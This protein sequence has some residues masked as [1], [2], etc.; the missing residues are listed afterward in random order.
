MFYRRSI[1]AETNIERRAS[2]EVEEGGALAIP[3][4]LV[5]F[6]IVRFARLRQ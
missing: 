6:E 1:E 2:A 4:Q 5:K 3:E